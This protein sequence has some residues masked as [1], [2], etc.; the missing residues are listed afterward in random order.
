MYTGRCNVCPFVVSNI[1]LTNISG[2]CNDHESIHAEHRVTVWDG[3]TS[4]LPREFWAADDAA[5]THRLRYSHS[6]ISRLGQGWICEVCDAE[7]IE[8]FVYGDDKG[9]PE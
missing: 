2:A 7:R 9:R 8:A 4:Q 3:P 6:V 1:M 5:E